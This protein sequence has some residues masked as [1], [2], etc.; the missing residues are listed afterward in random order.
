MKFFDGPNYQ[1]CGEIELGKMQNE[2]IAATPDGKHFLV[3]NSIRDEIVALG[4]GTRKE[5]F[6]IKSPLR[7]A[8]K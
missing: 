2:S 6:R 4:A 8:A 7:L 5:A 1:K 3:T